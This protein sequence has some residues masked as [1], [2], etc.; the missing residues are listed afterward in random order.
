VRMRFAFR[1][2]VRFFA[3]QLAILRF[4]SVRARVRPSDCAD[5]AGLQ[6]LFRRGV[7]ERHR[8][9]HEVGTIGDRCGTAKASTPVHC[10]G[11]V[12]GSVYEGQQTA[13]THANRDNTGPRT[14]RLETTQTRGSRVYRGVATVSAVMVPTKRL[15]DFTRGPCY[16]AGDPPLTRS[17]AVRAVSSAVGKVWRY[18]SVV[19]MF[20]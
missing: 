10:G 5:L 20:V 18:F 14:F 11:S 17:K 3:P 4:S 8:H 7:E 13:S 19:A 12:H 16:L 2:A 1:P 15:V 6:T 9:N